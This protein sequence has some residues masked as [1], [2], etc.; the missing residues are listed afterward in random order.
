MMADF[1]ASYGEMEAMAG[2]LDAVARTSARCS[3]A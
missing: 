3:T 1:E 2:K